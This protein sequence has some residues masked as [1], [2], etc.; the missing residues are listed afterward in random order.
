VSKDSRKRKHVGGDLI[1]TPSVHSSAAGHAKGEGKLVEPAPTEMMSVHISSLPA[2]A[3][4]DK[5][6]G[7]AAAR[8]MIPFINTSRAA[9][10]FK[11][12]EEAILS[13]SPARLEQRLLRYF[14]TWS[15][16]YVSG[17]VT[18]IIDLQRWGTEHNM[19]EPDCL[20]FDGISVS[21][22]LEDVDLKA[23]KEFSAA[24]PD[25]D[26][27]Q[28]LAGGSQA[29]MARFRYLRFAQL[30][31]FIPIRCDAAPVKRQCK[32]KRQG[33]ACVSIS[34]RAQC[35]MERAAGEADSVFTRGV[36][37]GLAATGL[38]TLRHANARRTLIKKFQHGILFAVCDLD[39]KISDSE[40][41]PRPCWTSERGVLGNRAWIDAILEAYKGIKFEPN[42][43]PSF[44]VRAYNAPMI[45]TPQGPMLDLS[46][47]TAWKGEVAESSARTIA[48]LRWILHTIGGFP[49]PSL[50]DLGTHS[51]KHFL[52]NVARSREESSEAVN[53]IGKW[54]G[55]EA[56]AA[57]ARKIKAASVVQHSQLSMGDT[58]SAEGAE[59]VVPSIVE[60]QIA[61]CRAVCQLTPEASLPLR[62]GWEVFRKHSEPMRLASLAPGG[63][64]RKRAPAKSKALKLSIA[65]A[66][67]GTAS[68]KPVAAK[69]K[70]KA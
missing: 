19:S 66:A 54:S 62:Q 29:K 6:K 45:K 13:L 50:T 58:Y 3:R 69:H 8:R 64:T 7:Y 52:P 30:N 18:T 28:R 31:A 15:A 11:T 5:A 23:R 57:D 47:A 16:G 63:S 10:I 2:G 9:S 14:S 17:S 41:N 25:A 44:L 32:T 68:A 37:G 36:A 55:S 46:R 22:Y 12:T 49:L 67:T 33:K 48:A 35:V 65:K 42:A 53:E 4:A 27:E 34:L 39:A 1:P 51:H 20:D 38:L 56:Q 26:P 21:E 40:Q 43:L 60:R 70:R 61:A 24:H 59:F